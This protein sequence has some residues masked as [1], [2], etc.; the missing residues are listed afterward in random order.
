M[1]RKQQN[2]CDQDPHAFGLP[3]N[4]LPEV[5]L[6]THAFHHDRGF[7]PTHLAPFHALHVYEYAGVMRLGDRQFNLR[8]G[9][10]SITPARIQATYDLP[11]GGYHWCVH[12]R[13][14]PARG[15]RVRLATF[16]TPPGEVPSA[17]ER[18]AQIA[19]L[20][21]EQSPAA[22]R[23]ARLLLQDLLLSLASPPAA[24]PGPRNRNRKGA[25]AGPARRVHPAVERAARALVQHLDRPLDVPRLATD[26]GL[27]QNYLAKRFRAHY[28]L[29]LQAYQARQRI[30]RADLLLRTTDLP[31]K[32]VAAQVGYPDPHHFNKTFRRLIGVAPS[33][34]RQ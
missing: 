33:T 26:A 30:A 14:P 8:P 23:R 3:L 24:D 21:T 7:R 9:C 29:T 10:Y 15:E 6:A 19:L 16:G 2:K 1:V 34:R 18:I 20:S 4:G 22:L 25:N 17:A 12:F 31:V 13:L 11:D 5:Q 28:G 27:S 32:A